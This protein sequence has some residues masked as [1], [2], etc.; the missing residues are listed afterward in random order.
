MNLTDQEISQIRES[1]RWLKPEIE[2]VAPKFYD[3][4]FRRDPALRA[5]FRDNLDEQGMR[6]MTAVSVIT[7]YLDDPIG[8]NA[9]VARLAE[10]HRAMQIRAKDYHSMEEA[11]IDT[12][13]E[14]LGA[15]FSPDMQRAWRHAFRQIGE[16]MMEDTDPDLIAPVAPLN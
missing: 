15:R 1:M 12:F 16:A 6:F 14:A 9:E 10:G 8:L 2:R 7:D 13:R 3:D 4:L 5:M 11:L